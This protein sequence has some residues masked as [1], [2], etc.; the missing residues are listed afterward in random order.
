MVNTGG[1]LVGGDRI[2]TTVKLGADASASIATQAAEKV[3]RAL[4][5]ASHIRADLSAGPGARL[6][7]LPQETILFEGARLDRRLDIDI[8]GSARLLAAETVLFGRQ[9]RGERLT[10]GLLQDGWRLKIDGK[11]AWADAIR[12]D[13]D[14][15]AARA[16][17]FGFGDAAGYATLVIAGDGAESFMP[18][19]RGHLEA[20]AYRHD[21]GVTLVNGVVILRFMAPDGKDLRA[22]LTAAILA[23]RPAVMGWP[24]ALPR[25]WSI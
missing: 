23:L 20:A 12:L 21:A 16:R 4:D 11:L 13:G 1:G 7:W 25:A 18:L 17:P 5:A 22:M 24:A 8:A 9:A 2:V 10:R 19:A 6:E 14:V 15:K 3:Y